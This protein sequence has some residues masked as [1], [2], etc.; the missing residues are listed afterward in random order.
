MLPLTFSPVPVNASTSIWGVID[1][2]QVGTEYSLHI[3]YF[4]SHCIMHTFVK[5]YTMTHNYKV[6]ITYK[7]KRTGNAAERLYKPIYRTFSRRF[8]VCIIV[9]K[10]IVMTTKDIYVLTYILKSQYVIHLYDA[11]CQ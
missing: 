5:K 10:V 3:A 9:L 7:T 4:I 6:Y 1:E 8:Y 2:S 11:F